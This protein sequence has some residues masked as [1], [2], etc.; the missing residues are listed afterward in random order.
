MNYA[1]SK[2]FIMCLKRLHTVVYSISNSDCNVFHVFLLYGE[3]DKD[4]AHHRNS[5]LVFCRHHSRNKVSAQESLEQNL[6]LNRVCDLRSLLR[7]CSHEDL[8]G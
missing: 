5:F 7:L 6:V 2:N 4:A 1:V 8:C 3:R